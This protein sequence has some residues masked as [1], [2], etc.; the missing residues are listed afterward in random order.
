MISTLRR[1][2]ISAL[3]PTRNRIAEFRRMLD[4]LRFTARNPV[5]VV[6]YVDDDDPVRERYKQIEGVKCII[7]PRISAITQCWNECFKV[8]TGDIFMQGNDDVIFRTPGWDEMVTQEFAAYADKILMVHGSDLG[9]HHDHGNKFGPHPFVHRRWIETVG[10]FIPP[11]F[12]SDW[13]DTWVN[14]LANAV[15]R[16][17]YLPF[18]VEHMH[19]LMKKAGKD[20]TTLDRLAREKR[21]EPRTLYGQLASRREQDAEKLRASMSPAKWSILILTQPTR[22][23]FL[24]CLLAV[25]L[26][27]VQAAEG[28][29]LIVSMCDPK[30][31]LG[32]NR[33]QMRQKAE[34]EYLCFVDDDDLVPE[35][36]VER[37]LPL[38]DGVD[39]IGFQLHQSIDGE[40]IGTSSHSLR[41]SNWNDAPGPKAGLF[42]RDIT[43]LNPMRR[44]LALL[45]PIK[46]GR[47]EDVRWADVMRARGVVKTEHYLDEVM[48][49]YQKHTWH[50]AD[51]ALGPPAPVPPA[52]A[53]PSTPAS[54]EVFG[55]TQPAV[56]PIIAAP[57]PPTKQAEVS[58]EEKRME[59]PNCH[60]RMTIP[61]S[62][63]RHC[64]ECGHD[65]AVPKQFKF[66]GIMR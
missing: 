25:L 30:L 34:G 21:D 60:S 19:F 28:V 8:A 43:Y 64:N 44:E 23:E 10:Y 14:D 12:C 11:W 56:V 3:C 65:F 33:E 7:G 45:E 37:I 63:G 47:G 61:S 48:Y 32:A 66:P 54:H 5:E 51:S 29:E 4:S 2:R 20:A 17:R 58:S 53:P 1:A 57:V 62:N 36:Y 22:V 9:Y 31:T 52:P 15:D 50:E 49:L 24:K 6:I 40:Q 18:V 41:H 39:Y 16:R 59:C 27:Q 26:P 13:G 42:S 38:L 35:N 55:R 46:G